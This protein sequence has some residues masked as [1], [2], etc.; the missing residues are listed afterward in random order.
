MLCFLLAITTYVPDDYNNRGCVKDKALLK[1][2]S[3]IRDRYVAMICN[4]RAKEN[5]C[6]T[7]FMKEMY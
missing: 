1:C 5:G 7:N 4:N 3:Q 2:I 6:T